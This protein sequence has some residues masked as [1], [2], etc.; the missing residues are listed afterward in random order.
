M[1]AVIA[2]SRCSKTKKLYA[3]RFERTGRDWKYT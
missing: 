1:D 3:I 2:L